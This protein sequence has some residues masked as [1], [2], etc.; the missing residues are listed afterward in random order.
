M[1]FIVWRAGSHPFLLSA[2]L[3]HTIEKIFFSVS[4]KKKYSMK[5][6]LHLRCGNWEG[7]LYHHVYDR[8]SHM[9]N[10]NW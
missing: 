9:N 1:K 10:S 4:A 8:K 6:Q 5:L 3:F 7:I 2:V